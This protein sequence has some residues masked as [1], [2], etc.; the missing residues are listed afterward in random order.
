[1][2]GVFLLLLA[3]TPG[4]LCLGYV[5]RTLLTT[6]VYTFCIGTIALYIINRVIEPVKFQS[7]A[8]VWSLVILCSLGMAVIG[9]AAAETL[10]LITGLFPGETFSGR[11]TSG[12]KISLVVSLAVALGTY[13]YNRMQKRLQSQNIE[14]QKKIETD[15]IRSRQQDEDVQ[16][17]REIQQGLLPK[18][19]PQIVGYQVTGTWQPALSVGGDYYDVLPLRDSSLGAVIA[20]VVGKGISAALLMANLQAAVRAFATDG[21][22]PA[23]LCERINTVMCSNVA[24]GKFITLFY[25]V[26]DSTKRKLTYSNAGH[27]PPILLRGE[28]VFRLEEGGALLGVFPD[29]KYEQRSIDLQAGDRILLFT[30]GLSE[31][32]DIGGK[33]FGED[34]LVEVFREV[35]ELPAIEI[36]T[37]VLETVRRFCR[38]NFRDDA[39]LLVITVA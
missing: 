10:L 29:W 11:F 28:D 34:R 18:N 25:C 26:L 33:E 39:T 27:N 21:R 15:V 14:L 7:E 17:A 30:D 35:R 6:F 32:E 4:P 13:A 5:L 1:V 16:K 9:A 12:L 31:A 19:V 2:I 38:G 8:V 37:R 23:E 3:T 36:Q 20:D 24:S 22:G